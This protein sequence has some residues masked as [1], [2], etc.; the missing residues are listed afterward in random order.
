M[1]SCEVQEQLRTISEDTNAFI[2]LNIK[3]VK[4]NNVIIR[5]V[6]IEE[7]HISKK[8]IGTSAHLIITDRNLV[9]IFKFILLYN[10]GI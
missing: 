3:C 5:H 8:E 2:A 9:F 6:M 1:T 10:V 4:Q 7:H